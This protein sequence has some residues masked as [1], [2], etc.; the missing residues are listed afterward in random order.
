VYSL[1]IE[2]LPAEQERLWRELHE[3]GRAHLGPFLHPAYV[4]AV[5]AV[6]P[7]VEVGIIT[8]GGEVQGFLP[9]RRSALG[10]ALPLGGRLCV[11]AGAVTR[12]GSLWSPVALLKALGLR[13]LRLPN[14]PTE[15]ASL[16]PFQSGA[17]TTAVIDVSDGFE[18]FEEAQRVSGSGLMRQTARLNRKASREVG[19]ARF[20]WHCPDEEPWLRLLEWK[21]QQRTRTRTPN[22]LNLPWARSLVERLRTTVVEGFGGAVSTLHYGDTL[23]AVHFGIHTDAALHYWLATYNPELS[24]YSPGATCLVE[25]VKG[26][27]ERGMQRVDLGVGDESFKVRARTGTQDLATTTVSTRVF[28]NA[29]FRTADGMRGWSRKS[30]VGRGLRGARRAAI[31]YSYRLRGPWTARP[32]IDADVDGVST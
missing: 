3:A 16:R 9:Y 29:A 11:Q 10:I 24:R 21:D 1:S 19:P 30:Y 7:D 12:P 18:S 31:R 14:T 5:S 17:T 22:V 25:L 6:R 2:E 20:A 15:D 27:A 32:G 23:A 4:R 8:E 13:G 28:V 26:A